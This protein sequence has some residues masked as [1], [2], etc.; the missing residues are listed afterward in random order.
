MAK[1]YKGDY[2]QFCSTA[3][4]WTETYACGARTNNNYTSFIILFIINNAPPRGPPR[5]RELS[6]MRRAAREGDES[7]GKLMEMGFSREQCVAALESNDYDE[8]K[9]LDALLSG[10]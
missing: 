4:Y 1:Q 5:A 3:K 9:A 6:P 8:N 10:A 2:R 7:V